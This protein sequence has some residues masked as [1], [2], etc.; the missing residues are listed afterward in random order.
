MDRLNLLFTEVKDE[1]NQYEL[2][3]SRT[4]SV[5]LR[6]KLLTLQKELMTIRKE[7]IYRKKDP[8]LEVPD[9]KEV[10]P[11]VPEEVQAIQEVNLEELPKLK[12][13]KKVLKVRC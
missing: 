2:L 13:K 4:N 7:L 3:S 11:V 5:L 6:R 10:V 9:V 8:V 1:F 12:R